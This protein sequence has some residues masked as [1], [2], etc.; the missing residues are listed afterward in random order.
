MDILNI[1]F[2]SLLPYAID[3]FTKI[4]GEEY[5]PIISERVNRAFIVLYHDI[6][7]LDYYI[8]FIKSC[9]KRE[10]SIELLNRIGVDIHNFKKDNYTEPLNP[11]IEKILN[12]YI[13]SSNIGFDK[14]ADY[15][16]PLRAFNENNNTDTEKL[17]KNK[18]KLINYLRGKDKEQITPENFNS[19][20]DTKE[21]K[22]LL[23]RINEINKIYSK[24]FEEYINWEMQLSSYQEYVDYEKK[25]KEEILQKSKNKIFLEIL[26][27]LPPLI[28]NSILNKTEE[29][30]QEAILGNCDISGESRIEMFINEQMS[31]LSCPNVSIFEKTLIIYY[32]SI[33]LKIFGIEISENILKCNNEEDIISY[34]NLIKQEDIKKYIP[35][36]EVI[37]Q[38]KIIREKAYEESI[39]EYYITRKDVINIFKKFGDNSS[40]ELVY[41]EIKNKVV[42]ILHSGGINNNNEFISIMFYT[43]RTNGCGLLSHAFMHEIGHIIDQKSKGCG[44]EPYNNNEK[45]PYDN[46]F[47]KYEK[48]NETINDIF[49]IEAVDLLHKQEI[50]LIEPKEFVSF[51]R[52]NV[53]TPLIAKD[54]LKPLLQKYRKQVIKA[55]I[56]QN[57]E[58][59]TRYIGKD[60]FEKLV[61]AVNKVDYLWRNGFNPKNNNSPEDSMA[62]EYFNQLEKIKKIYIDIDNYHNNID[63]LLVTSDEKSKNR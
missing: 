59:L 35:S 7:G 42:C 63:S 38:F 5:R 62:I 47:R 60:N 19:F 44:F 39:R 49:T 40:K 6:E 11:D 17:I 51:D 33:Y 12:F 43:I 18:I 31:K 32:Q 29:E 16:A 2:D 1:D 22:E 23:I 56:D 8:S 61:D 54:L 13:E 55:K 50:Y 52:S 15:S 27:N 57:P 45:N 20:C 14:N 24:L 48:F 41:N 3:A 53:N 4:Y 21:Y 28:K 30:I 25:R 36:D 34:L 9:K 58:E 10:Y 26:N 37:N 46:T